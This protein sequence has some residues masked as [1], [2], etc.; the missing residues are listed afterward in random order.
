MGGAY[1]ESGFHGGD[2]VILVIVVVATEAE[3]KGIAVLLVP[4]GLDF[5]GLELLLHF[6]EDLE[7]R[8]CKGRV[9]DLGKGDWLD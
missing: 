6:K 2:L 9:V 3:E 5:F 4:D 1:I 7:A 8:F